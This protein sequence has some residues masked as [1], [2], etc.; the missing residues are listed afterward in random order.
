MIDNALLKT[1]K[2]AT[3]N[4]IITAISSFLRPLCLA[5]ESHNWTG[6]RSCPGPRQRDGDEFRQGRRGYTVSRDIYRS[7]CIEKPRCPP[8]VAVALER[9]YHDF[10]LNSG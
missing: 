6:S 4:I 2:D 8:D 10:L 7:A 1:K 9:K 5:V 3:I